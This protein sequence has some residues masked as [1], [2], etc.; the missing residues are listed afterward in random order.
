M[1]V[2]AKTTADAAALQA[3]IRSGVAAI[4]RT[5][6]ISFFATLEANVAQS[7]GPQRLVATL[8]GIFAAIALGLSLT[9]LYSVL[10]TS[11]RSAPPRSASAW[12]S[13]RR[14]PPSSA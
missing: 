2:I 11:C 1:N 4:D 14:G 12:R 5:Q 6:A 10:C 9:G 13:A 3:A 7:L 8:T